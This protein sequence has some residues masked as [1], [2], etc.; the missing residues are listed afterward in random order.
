[1][2]SSKTQDYTDIQMLRHRFGRAVDERNWDLFESLFTEDVEADYTAFG[3]PQSRGIE[4]ISKLMRHSFR[5]S[6]MKSHQIYSNFEI[7]VGDHTATSLS[8][9]LGRHHIPNFPGGDWFTL[10]ARYHDD[11]VRTPSGWRLKQLRLEVLFVE[12]N[13]NIVS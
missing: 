12:G 10:H 8:S 9:L 7:A 6:E 11:L 13:L 4:A 5:R 1:M 3:A 2:N